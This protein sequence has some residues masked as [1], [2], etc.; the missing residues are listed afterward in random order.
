MSFLSLTGSYN[1]I[2][3][4]PEGLFGSYPGGFL[5]EEQQR[6]RLPPGA[7]RT[8]G[9][10]KPRRKRDKTRVR[11]ASYRNHAIANI[12]GNNWDHA[13]PVAPE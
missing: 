4:F 5:P 12:H 7:I 11:M 13:H 8:Q 10:I 2:Q 1:H 3:I 9:S 6:L